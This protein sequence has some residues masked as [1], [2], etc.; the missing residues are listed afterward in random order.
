MLLII[1]IT[2]KLE[3]VTGMHIG[4][5]GAFSA[6][7]A[8]DSPV[9]RDPLSTLPMIPGSSLKGKLRALLARQYN[10]EAA[11]NPDGDNECIRQLF[12]CAKK[13]EVKRSRLIFSDMLMDN[14]DELK[15]RGLTS[16]TEVKFENS[17]SRTTAVANPRQIERVVRGTTFPL[18]IV[19]ETDGESGI[20]EETVKR[21]M[22]ILAMG[23]RLLEYD[24]LG[25]NGSRG[26]GKVKLSDIELDIPFGELSDEAFDYCLEQLR[27]SCL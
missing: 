13:G 12:G 11:M 3:A 10:T 2:G 14:W 22:E 26:Y 21:D 23:F 15:E 18:D 16:K 24:Y 20:D 6:I 17:I 1:K 9:I 4:G 7:G 8:V 5:S 19:Y 25:G 27:G